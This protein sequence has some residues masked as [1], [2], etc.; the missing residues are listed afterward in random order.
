MEVKIIETKEIK[1]LD[2]IDPEDGCNYAADYI[3][4]PAQVS[5]EIA[6]EYRT[7]NA[8]DYAWWADHLEAV[9]EAVDRK[10]DMLD[11]YGSAAVEE[12]E[13]ARGV[14]SGDI[15]DDPRKMLAAYDDLEP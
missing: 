1:N 4:N 7:I 12:A 13:Q 5:L 6:G 15:E 14:G 8:E 9:Q 11:M 10:H 3:A 2:L